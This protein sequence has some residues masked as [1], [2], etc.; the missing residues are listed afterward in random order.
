MKNKRIVD[1]AFLDTFHTMNC[2]VCNRRGC[3][4]AHLKTRGSG[5]DDVYSNVLAFC[6]WHHTEQSAKGWKHMADKYKA[7]SLDLESKGW[8]FDDFNKLIRK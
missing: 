1:R 2:I 8:T 5:G 3:D 6:R 4:P 7:V